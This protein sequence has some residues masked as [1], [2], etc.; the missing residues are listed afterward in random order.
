MDTDRTRRERN[1]DK[2]DEAKSYLQRWADMDVLE[3]TENTDG[4]VDL[5]LVSLLGT[6][7]KVHIEAERI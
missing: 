1:M 5:F 3:V 7:F 6:G 4:S 2:L